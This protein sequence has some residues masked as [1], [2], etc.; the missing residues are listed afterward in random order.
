MKKVL[1]IILDGLGDEPIPDLADQ[2]PLEA[3]DT[4]YM[5]ELA[6]QGKLGLA[7]PEFQ[8]AVPTSEEGHFQLF[9][10]D[11][12]KLGLR[13]G[14]V[15][16]AG[17][18]IDVQ[19]G[20][21]A[22]RGNFGYVENGK[23][24]DRRAGRIK[25]TKE[26]INALREIDIPGVEFLI[27]SA[28]EHRLGIVI[29]GHGLSGRISDGDPFYSDLDYQIQRVKP[30]DKTK[31]AEKT[32]E[33]L[34]Q[35]LDK[36]HQ[37][38]KNHPVNKKRK[39]T[40]LPP[41][42]YV[43]TRGACSVKKLESFKDKYNLEAACVAGKVLYKQIARMLGMKIIEV[44]GADGTA[45]TN[46]SG[47]ITAVGQA[48]TRYDFVFLHIKATDSLAEDGKFFEKKQF[49]EKIDQRLSSLAQPEDTVIC[50]S[51]DHSTCSLLKRHCDRPCP[52]LIWGKGKDSTSKFSEAECE[53]GELGKFKQINLM[54]F[55]TNF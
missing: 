44:D 30:L 29:R 32:A 24:I 48:L 14:I 41:A 46:L 12:E 27:K 17:A 49:L 55:L 35:F 25:D 15:T 1:L 52:V 22:L 16:A 31:Q 42:N 39:E 53:K 5:D 34:N 23:A 51:S 19:P 7:Q 2:T 37:V 4:P 21:V 11:S 50:I 9:G 10:Y 26:L 47:K 33:I 40:G 54:S 38:L 20:D 36:A 28:K 45:D 18:G 43:L 6:G 13:R 3:A 8:G